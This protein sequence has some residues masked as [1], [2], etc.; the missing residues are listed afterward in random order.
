MHTVSVVNK[1]SLFVAFRSHEVKSTP[2]IVNVPVENFLY[3]II[4]D[5]PYLVRNLYS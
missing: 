3:T 4:L 5:F 2:S 1:V